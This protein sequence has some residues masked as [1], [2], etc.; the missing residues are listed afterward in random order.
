MH[1]GGRATNVRYNTEKTFGV[2]KLGSGAKLLPRFRLKWALDGSCRVRP[3]VL[4]PI[5]ALQ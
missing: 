1:V 5:I 4:V 2:I 3:D